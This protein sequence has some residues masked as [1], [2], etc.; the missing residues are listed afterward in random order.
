MKFFTKEVKIALV[1]IIGIVV[2]FFGMN[3]LKG[4][5][6]FSSNNTYYVKF[7]NVSGLSVSAPVF[8]NGYKV[9]VVEAIDY[10]YADPSQIVV[11]IGLDKKLSMPR[12][13]TAEISSDLLGNVKLELNFGTNPADKLSPGDTITGGQKLGLMD[14]AGEMVPQIEQM[15]P[16]LDSILGQVNTLLADPALT[17]TIHNV[18]ELTARLDAT[19]QELHQLTGS[20]NRSVPGML[21]K[22]S[23]TLDHVE[24]LTAQI[25]EIDVNKM[26]E[27]VNKTLENVQQLSETLNSNQGTLGLLMRDTE[28]Y[29]HLTETMRDVDAL[30]V[31]FK[32]HPRRYINVSVFGK[33]SE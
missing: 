1:A 21:D 24:N 10:N 6:L 11:A 19:S 18:E 16:K 8:A 31:D 30:L 15:L 4:L 3:F 23:G 14:K 20:L 22:A 27:R 26:A 13:T 5:S 28:L 12:G 2:L 29:N 9:G 17:G 25:S 32:A 33:K 7:N